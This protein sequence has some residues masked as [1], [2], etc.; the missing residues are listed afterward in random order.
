MEQLRRIRQANQSTVL[1]AYLNTMIAFG[2]YDLYD[3][4]NKTC[5][6]TCFLHNQDGSQFFYKMK[7][8]LEPVYD[9]SDEQ[10]RALWLESATSMLNNSWVDGIFADRGRASAFVDLKEANITDAHRAAWD[11]GHAAMMAQTTELA[12]KF[13]GGRGI[14][15]ANGADIQ[16]VNARM[17]EDMRSNDTTASPPGDDIDLMMQ[18][19]GQR[20]IEAHEDNVA[21]GT[22]ADAVLAFNRSLAAYLVAAGEYTY[23][24]ATE[25]WFTAGGWMT[26]RVEYG[27]PLGPPKAVGVKK[28]CGLA[29]T[30]WTRE[31]ESGV[32]VF[33]DV[34]VWEHPCILWPVGP[35]GVMFRGPDG[36]QWGYVTGQL[37]DCEAY[38]GA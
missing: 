16:G 9:L 14:V 32:K 4:A 15:I 10:A 7:G 3:R 1:V 8:G 19:V 21:P 36:S 30:A 34:G 12:T 20:V 35:A 5:R 25:S 2:Q 38:L 18:Q 28:R 23:F 27:L 33:L 31:F 37:A 11:N 29:G 6:S 22:G 24:Q 26:P 17:F 13:A